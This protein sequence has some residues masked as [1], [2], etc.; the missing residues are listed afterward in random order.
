M[1]AKYFI[2]A[3]LIVFVFSGCKTNKDKKEI[4]ITVNQYVHHPNLKKT[5]DGVKEVLSQWSKENHKNIKYDI[6]VANADVSLATQIA[7]QQAMKNP[8]IMLALA[9]PSAQAC[10]KATN[11]IPIVFGAITDPVKAGLVKSLEHPGGNITGT[12][13]QWPYDKQFE[14]IRDIFPNAKKIGVVLNPGEAN[15]EASMKKIKEVS[16]K[17]GFEIIEAPVSSTSEI[18]SAA[19]SLVGKCDIFF[20]PADNTV[21]SG[22]EAFV[23]V[24]RTNNIPLFVGDE[25]SVEK[26]GI[27]T[28]GV[29]Y[30][31]LGKDTGKLIVRILNGEK[32]ADIP[33]VVGN[34][35]KLVVNEDAL[36]YFNITIP[37]KYLNKS[38]KEPVLQE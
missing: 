29:D 2:Q 12:S 27:A 30:Y 10:Q 16:K 19:N 24:S 32:P 28:F 8:D 38:I 22:L 5:M 6:Q 37:D 23:K 1:K 21:L 13:D 9:T 7:K 18:F 31:E 33:V 3:L 20:A 17:Y 36:K 4:L 25:G 34:K 14:L 26:G 11:T 15:T 35:G